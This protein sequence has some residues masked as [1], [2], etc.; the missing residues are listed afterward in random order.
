M[1]VL[2]NL[3][4]FLSLYFK[5]LMIPLSFLLKPCGE[6]NLFI[7]SRKFLTFSSLVGRKRIPVNAI[8]LPLSLTSIWDQL[9]QL[10]LGFSVEIWLI[11]L[12]CKHGESTHSSHPTLLCWVPRAFG[13]A[14]THTH[15]HDCGKPWITRTAKVFKWSLESNSLNLDVRKQRFRQAK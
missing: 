5:F 14:C 7:Y 6:M 15:T 13:C 1:W 11:W 3:W 10:E 12:W 4:E 2:W 9:K 8:S